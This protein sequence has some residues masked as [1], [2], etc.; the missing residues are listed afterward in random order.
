MINILYSNARNFDFTPEYKIRDDLDKIIYTQEYINKQNIQKIVQLESDLRLATVLKQ[1]KLPDQTCVN[2][3][4]GLETTLSS[5][6]L[7]EKVIS[8]VRAN[9]NT[10]I[11]PSLV[12]RQI[13]PT[14][15]S[16]SNNKSLEGL[17]NPFL[18][19]RTGNFLK[20]GSIM[21]HVGRV[22]IAALTIDRRY[23]QLPFIYFLVQ[24]YIG[25]QKMEEL[26]LGLD[27]LLSIPKLFKLEVNNKI[28]LNESGAL[29]DFGYDKIAWNYDKIAWK[30][31][32]E[33]QTLNLEI[34]GRD[35]MDM[36]NYITRIDYNI[37]EQDFISYIKTLD[38]EE[39]LNA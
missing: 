28:L 9:I 20:Y 33:A 37:T 3:S 30:I 4:I 24:H 6:A 19:F 11:K 2:F 26:D 1:I 15:T 17:A 27:K 34:E 7:K 8:A 25:K 14:S 21:H 31:V 36:E 29:T 13:L 16:T 5:E 22:P 12:F 10:L 38:Y 35:D 32:K 23:L 18:A 39:V